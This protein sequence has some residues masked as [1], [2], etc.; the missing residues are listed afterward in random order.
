[1]ANFPYEHLL[2]GLIFAVHLSDRTSCSI[3]LVAEDRELLQSNQVTVYF[4]S[5]QPILQKERLTPLNVLKNASCPITSVNLSYKTNVQDP[6]MM[7]LYEIVEN[8]IFGLVELQ[9]KINGRWTETEKFT[10][11][12]IDQYRLRYR[13]L[14]TVKNDISSTDKFTFRVYTEHQTHNF[15]TNTFI[16]NLIT[17]DIKVYHAKPFL[18]INVLNSTLQRQHL[19]SWLQ[20][21]EFTTPP[22]VDPVY[23]IF[24]APSFGTLFKILDVVSKRHRKLGQNMNFTQ[25]DV[26]SDRIFYKLRYE[27]FNVVNDAFGYKVW[28]PY[29]HSRLHTFAVTYFPGKNLILEFS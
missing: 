18:M 12:D 21:K 28:T 11:I 29:S 23:Q 14:M 15:T 24:K 8:P 2:N 19:F 9:N 20:I 3:D 4:E 13:H 5:F 17:A 22:S 1:L 10:Q 16:V 26:D 25:S 7:I 27:H 6:D